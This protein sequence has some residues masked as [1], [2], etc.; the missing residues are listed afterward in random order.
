M[1]LRRYFFR[2]GKNP[3]QLAVFRRKIVKSSFQN[4]GQDLDI[5]HDF[6][7]HDRPD[8]SRVQRPNQP[9]KDEVVERQ[10]TVKTQI[11]VAL[12]TGL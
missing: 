9:P 12:Q 5:F 4:G 11:K 2:W 3:A 7:R 6:N 1:M 10:Q 8:T